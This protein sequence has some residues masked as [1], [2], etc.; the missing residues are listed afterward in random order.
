V[1]WFGTDIY[2]GGTQFD[3]GGWLSAQQIFAQTYR[4]F[5]ALSTSKPVIFAEASSVEQG[6][7]K[8]QWITDLLANAPGVFPN[9]RAIVWFH[10]N[11]TTVDARNLPIADWRVNT[12]LASLQA[13]R[14]V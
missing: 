10:D 11:F 6:G 14:D 9:L 2:N 3:W 13:F 12:S 5:Q 1:D 4:T 7:S 8:A